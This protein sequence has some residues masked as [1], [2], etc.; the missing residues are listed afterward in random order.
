MAAQKVYQI[1]INGLTES[2]KAV[3][4]LNESLKTL[5]ARI[6]ALEGKTVS[7]GSSSSGGGSKSTSTSS[8]SE[9]AKLEKQIQQLEEKRVAHS[10]EIYQNYLAAKD[11]LKE[12]EKDQKQIAASERIAAKTYSNTISG[13]KQELADIKQVMQTVDLG[14]T[15]QLDKM[16]NRAKELNDKLKEIEQ[17]YGQ[18]GRNVGNYA[19][20]A[21]GFKGLHME[22]AGTVHE[23]DNARQALKTLQGE[24]RTLQVK[25]DQGILLSEEEAKRFKELPDVVAQLA[26]S[27]ADAGKPMDSLLDTMQSFTALAQVGKGFSTFFGLDNSAI[28]ESIQK[29]VAL[30]NAM[31]GLQAIQKQLQT[32]EGLGKVFAQGNKSIDSFVAK[33]TGAKV[34]MDGLEKSTKLGTTSV[35][36]FSTALKGLASAGVLAVIT[37]VFY[38]IEKGVEWLKEWISGDADLVSAEDALTASIEQQNKVLNENVD[39]I[40]KR[41]DAGEISKEQAKVETEQAYAKALA[42]TNKRLLEREETYRKVGIVQPGKTDLY[43]GNAIGDTG[44]TSF[45]GFKEGIKGIDDFN[46]RWDLLKTAVENGTDALNKWNYTADDAKDDFVHMSKLAGGDLVNAFNKMADGTREGTK[47]LVEYIR[48]MDELT[49]GRYSQAIKIGIDKGYLDEQFNFSY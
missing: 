28:D 33:I 46:R 1:Q 25:K 36:L 4:A 44:V 6:K 40:Q 15:D 47:A 14:D 2:V 24:L 9:E 43:L 23:F 41:L 37:A 42:E 11:V 10:K 30:Q 31:Q 22:V 29:L 39:L 49:S 32:T 5:E 34:G 35:R 26:S 12:T 16:V 27:I 8:L 38:A 13:M 48:H 19:S 45:G 20:A 3:D 7:V 17:S 18:F 21:E